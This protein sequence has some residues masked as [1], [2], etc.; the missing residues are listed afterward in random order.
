MPFHDL[1]R[2]IADLGVI[3][4]IGQVCADKG[5]GFACIAF[6]DLIDIFDTL[7]VENIAADAVGRIGRVGND[8]ALFE[9]V[10]NLANQSQ[11]GVLGIDGDNHS[12]TSS[13]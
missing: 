5:E 9:R 7:L 4:N 3:G 13:R 2:E 8:P 1:E 6:F 12:Y 11:L 10:H